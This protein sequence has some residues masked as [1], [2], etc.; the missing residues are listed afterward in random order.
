MTGPSNE[1]GH[2]L[3]ESKRR[4]KDFQRQHVVQKEHNEPIQSGLLRR[5]H[6]WAPST[7]TTRVRRKDDVSK[8]KLSYPCQATFAIQTCFDEPKQAL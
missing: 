3:Q 5:A 4:K 8:K 6:V 7:I 1:H 2:R